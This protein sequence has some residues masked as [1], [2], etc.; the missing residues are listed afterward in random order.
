MIFY[1]PTKETDTMPRYCGIT[2]NLTRRRAEHER[3]KRNVRNWTP[4]D[5]GRPFPSREAA[6]DWEDRQDAEHDPGGATALGPWYGY[7]F[8]YDR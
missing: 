5:G 8:D 3:E 2:T 1:A 6:Q 7:C 4:A